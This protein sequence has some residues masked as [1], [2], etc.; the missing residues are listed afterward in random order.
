MV[1]IGYLLCAYGL[2]V[3]RT[4]L[5]GGIAAGVHQYLALL[6]IRYFFKYI[7]FVVQVIIYNNNV[8]IL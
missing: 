5:T 8:V 2:I 1:R 3:V 4:V 6:L 7:E